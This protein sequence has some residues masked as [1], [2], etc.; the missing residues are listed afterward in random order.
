MVQS[1]H[2]FKPGQDVTCVPTAK[3]VGARFV[4][5]Q[6][7]GAPSVPHVK[8]SAAGDRSF[9]VVARDAEKDE[10]V[11]VHTGGIVPITAGE[12]LTAGSEVSAGADGKAV[13]TAADA[14][15]LGLVIADAADAELASIHLV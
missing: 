9:G 1:L 8:H 10:E 7:G 5:L 4:T 15:V 13:A 12:A 3:V 11:L 14:K 2:Y 6:T